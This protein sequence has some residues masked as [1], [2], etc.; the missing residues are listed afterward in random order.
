MPDRRDTSL[1]RA[2]Q[3]AIPEI[4]H[5]DLLALCLE[6]GGNGDHFRFALSVSAT[7]ADGTGILLLPII[8]N[9]YYRQSNGNFVQWRPATKERTLGHSPQEWRCLL[10]PKIGPQNLGLARREAKNNN[11]ILCLMEMAFPSAFGSASTEIQEIIMQV[12]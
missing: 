5:N 3:L 8:R 6:L 4:V 7:M 2:I 11:H 1:G 10:L 12:G 9:N